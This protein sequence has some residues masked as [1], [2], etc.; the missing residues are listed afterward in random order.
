M[1]VLRKGNRIVCIYAKLRTVSEISR[2]GWSSLTVTPKGQRR[3][4]PDS[5]E[6]KKMAYLL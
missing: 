4:E 6:S 3:R 5:F 1:P 2:D